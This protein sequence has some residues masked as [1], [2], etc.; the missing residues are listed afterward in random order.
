MTFIGGGSLAV[1][2]RLFKAAGIGTG[3]VDAVK[4]VNKRD[5]RHWLM[6]YKL[7]GPLLL[8]YSLISTSNYS[9]ELSL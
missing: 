4:G 7:K 3:V 2:G 9:I 5:L 1:G 6:M 8:I